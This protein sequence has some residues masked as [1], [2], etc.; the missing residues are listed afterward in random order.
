MQAAVIH[1]WELSGKLRVVRDAFKETQQND[2]SSS[3][4]INHLEQ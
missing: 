4:S 3:S 2:K 1:H